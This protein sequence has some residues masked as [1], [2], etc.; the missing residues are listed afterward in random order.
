MLLALKRSRWIALLQH[1]RHDVKARLHQLLLELKLRQ[2][3]GA[4]NQ[5]P[6][7]DVTVLT[8]GRP[9]DAPN[10][11]DHIVLEDLTLY[12]RRVDC[13]FLACTRGNP[14]VHEDLAGQRLPN[15]CHRP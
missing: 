2:Y 13:P 5:V 12:I 11:G 15:W 1:C 8:A 4:D 6:E 7:C 3:R 9:A 14:Q 10:V